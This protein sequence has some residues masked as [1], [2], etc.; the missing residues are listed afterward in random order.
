M[1]KRRILAFGCVLIIICGL[2]FMVT[3]KIKTVSSSSTDITNKEFVALVTDGGNSVSQL[4]TSGKGE[5]QYKDNYYVALPEKYNSFDKITNF[6]G[7]YFSKSYVEDF[8]KRI[9]F[10]KKDTSLLIPEGDMG[11]GYIYDS[12]KVL[13]K[14]VNN[15]ELIIKYSVLRMDNSTEKNQITLV[16]EDN[17]WKI[18]KWDFLI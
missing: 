8:I 3:S 10:T 4:L 9:G 2:I 12:F 6:L 15:D 11:I 7:Q 14:H 13:E 17:K 5:V 18:K 1:S 16:F